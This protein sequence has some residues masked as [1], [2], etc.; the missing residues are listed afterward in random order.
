MGCDGYWPL[1]DNPERNVVPRLAVGLH[2]NAHA[3]RRQ[4]SD[5][6]EVNH[7]CR[8]SLA[9]DRP[10]L[11]RQS[12]RGGHVHDALRGK[13]YRVAIASLGQLQRG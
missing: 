2:E 12:R 6:R 9:Q 4:E 5:R 11:I 3:G 8:W 7:Q 13:H 1:R 10:D